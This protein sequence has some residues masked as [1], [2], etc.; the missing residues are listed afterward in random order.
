MNIERDTGRQTENRLTPEGTLLL[1]SIAIL[2]D[3]LGFWTVPPR[4]NYSSNSAF[5]IEMAQHGTRSVRPPFR[6]RA[7][8]PFVARQLPL[9]ADQA[10]VA[11]SNVS[12]IGCVFVAMLISKRVGLSIPACIFGATALFFSRAFIYNYVNPYMTDA[13]ALLAIFAM[14]YV[15]LGAQEIAFGT[16]AVIGILAHEIT[17]FLVPAVLF[18]RRWRRGV[19]ASIIPTLVLLLTRFWLGT[20]Y[21][22][23]LK[24][25]FLL[26]SVHISHP[27]DWVRAVAL[28][29]YMLWPLIVLG[30][31]M[32]PRKRF[33]LLVCT[34]LLTGGA[35]LLSL[36][37]LDTERTYSILAPVVAVGAATVFEGLWK[38]A[39]TKAIGLF[40]VV[41]ADLASAEAYRTGTRDL[42]VLALFSAPAIIYLVYAFGACYTQAREG[43]RIHAAEVRQFVDEVAA[44]LG[45][46]SHGTGNRRV[47]L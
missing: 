34:G 23:S 1:L 41:L 37:V 16:A 19:A 30:I 25:E 43:R 24:K 35:V 13:V 3:L 9:P 33:P 47:A 45:A 18:S 11:I 5:Y 31:A 46:T 4:I 2:F 22:G 6:Y 26:V 12:L 40:T 17:V 42:R 15:Y 14:V 10:F 28:T 20:G 36:F 27:L 38:Q 8:V 32:L 39:G 44:E 29:W 7:L 21:A